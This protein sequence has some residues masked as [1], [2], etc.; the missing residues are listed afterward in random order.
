MS[1]GPSHED[2][3]DPLALDR[4]LC[5][6]FYAASNLVIRHYRP[7]LS[8]L[9]LT[10]PQYLVMLVLWEQDGVS[11]GDICAR[12]HLDS[13]TVTPMLKRMASLGLLERS[14]DPDDERRVLVMLTV[15]GQALR[16]RAVSVP[17]IMSKGQDPN[18]LAE[19]R[20]VL[21]EV[22]KSLASA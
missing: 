18:D 1:K 13:G 6:Q 12:L 14:R 15:E 4:Q 2:E 7:V 3:P 11:V 19:L 17:E 5:F 8:E 16:A 9:G 21:S 10:Y 22:V 20:E